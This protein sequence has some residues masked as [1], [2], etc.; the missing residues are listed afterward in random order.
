[1]SSITSASP[2][3]NAMSQRRTPAQAAAPTTTFTPKE[4]LGM[5]RRRMWMIMIITTLMIIASM[6]LW[7]VLL[8]LAPRYTSRGL[9]KCFMPIQNDML[10]TQQI[11][12]TPGLIELETRSK[13]QELR[14]ESFLAEILARKVV[15][16]S[17]WYKSF[18]ND[19][20]GRFKGLKK[21]FGATPLRDTDF[22]IVSMTT[23]SA[24]ES[25]KILDNILLLFQQ[26]T[27]GMTRT[28]LRNDLNAQRD[29]RT[30]LNRRIGA[31][32]RQ[33]A[34]I[35]GSI[36]EPGW[37]TGV[38]QITLELEQWGQEKM[39]LQSILQELGIQIANIQ[40]ETQESGYSS[41]INPGVGIIC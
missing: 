38:S 13:A 29:V 41:S 2:E 37:E 7:F 34:E 15:R 10:S 35:R 9:I 11:I 33:L 31:K 32:R 30:D 18:G 26:K 16:D 1:M 40:R 20:E 3:R 19:I 21:R 23:A 24:K 14:N 28:G 5:L 22:V 39:R 36:D 12:P 6:G 17:K 4:I 8:K 25:K 27:E